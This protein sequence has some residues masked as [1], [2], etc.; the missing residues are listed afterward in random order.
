MAK[1]K[2]QV[3]YLMI[4]YL[5]I[6]LD[7]ILRLDSLMLLSIDSSSIKEQCTNDYTVVSSDLIVEVF[8]YLFHEVLITGAFRTSP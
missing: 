7:T 8:C 5:M 4:N 3:D 6:Y 2:L 1:Q